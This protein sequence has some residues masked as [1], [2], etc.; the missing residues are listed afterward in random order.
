[1]AQEQWSP[2]EAAERIV[3]GEQPARVLGVS[4]NQIQALAVLGYNLYQQG[5]LGEA[6][7]MF[8]G[9]AAL[10]NKS[11]FGFAGLGAVAL[12]KRPPDLDTA[13]SN[14][15]RAVELK[16]TDAT[17][18]A[19][20]GEVLLRQGKVEDAKPY[21]EKAFQLDPGHKDPGANRAR[22]IVG[23]LDVIVKEVQKRLQSQAPLQAKAS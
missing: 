18:Q 20:L 12:A 16:P 5:K 10:D 15:S 19:N 21:L 1:M 3:A 6:E 14:L 13:Y 23:G 17:V 4:E 8:R 22:A 7:T 9:I 2:A 11:Y